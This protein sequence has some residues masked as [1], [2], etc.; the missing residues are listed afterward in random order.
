MQED[1]E[2]VLYRVVCMKK[3]VEYYKSILRDK[4]YTVRPFKYDPEEELK[5]KKKRQKME[6]DRGKLYQMI[7]GWC[8]SSFSDT[9]ASWLHVKSI[10]LFVEAVLRYGFGEYVCVLMKPKPGQERRLRDALNDLYSK[11]SGDSSVTE[12]LEAGEQDLSGTGADFY[13]YVYTQ[14]TL[15]ENYNP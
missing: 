9:F 15:S 13:P 12:A 6:E 14:L 7:I 3:G 4:R 5:E 1:D 10:R 11:L 2:F 8:N